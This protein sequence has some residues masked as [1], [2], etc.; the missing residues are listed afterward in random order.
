MSIFND[1]ERNFLN[2]ISAL[3]TDSK[4][5]EILVGLTI[6]ETIFYMEYAQKRIQG[7]H[8]SQNRDRYLEL[9]DKHERARFAVLG[10]EHYIRT[11]NPPIQ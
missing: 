11:E 8:D 4:G 3:S 10:A 2:E 5:R 6:E 9:H 1:A 7:H